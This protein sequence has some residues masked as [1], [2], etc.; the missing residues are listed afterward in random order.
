MKINKVKSDLFVKAQFANLNKRSTLAEYCV[1]VESLDFYSSKCKI[2]SVVTMSDEEYISFSNNLLENR[3]WLAGEGGCNSDSLDT[4]AL[5]IKALYELD[6]KQME[7]WKKGVYELCIAVLNEETR[8]W[9]L[10]NPQGYSY[11]RYVGLPLG[12]PV[13]NY[14][15]EQGEAV[16][17]KEEENFTI[18]EQEDGGFVVSNNYCWVSYNYNEKQ[19]LG[20][21]YT[22][23]NN[24]PTFY[25][26][27]SRSHKRAAKLL[28]EKFG[29]T[30]TMSQAMRIVEEGKVKCR[31][32]CA[33][34]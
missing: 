5:G 30:T 27:T 26:Q 15:P 14:L 1:E 28:K 9:Y 11:A 22:D 21:D 20:R 29:P 6:D 16:E 8:E 10:V 32:Y 2:I 13:E 18:T 31:S 23:Q 25:N 7:Q 24:L 33:M 19:F 34:D 12:F 17:D 3:E 4:D